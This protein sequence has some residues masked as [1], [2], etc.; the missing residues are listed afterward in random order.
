MKDY[1]ILF[2][3][4]DGTIVRPDH[5]IEESTRIAIAEMKN[6]GIEVVLATGRPLHEIM[7]TA[8]ELQIDSFVAYNGSLAIYKGTEIFKEFMDGDNLRKYL[9]VAKAHNHEIILYSRNK[10][11][12]TNLETP[13][14]KQFLEQFHLKKNEMFTGESINEILSL[15]LLTPDENE[16]NHYPELENIHF[17]Q[18]NVNGYTGCYD[19]ILDNVNKGVAVKKILDHLLIPEGLAIAFGDGLNDV[20]MLSTVGESFAMGN[21]HPKLK[22]YAKHVTTDVHNSGVYNGL[23]SLGLLEKVKS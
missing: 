10:N 16:I 5:T 18:V 17:S 3:D 7:E 21:A 2:L 1:K 11:Y 19:V 20:E 23:K 15:T 13:L 4:I 6:K 9:E 12:L 8:K 22:P 14:V